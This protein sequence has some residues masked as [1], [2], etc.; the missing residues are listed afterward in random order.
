MLEYAQEE[1]SAASGPSDLTDVLGFPPVLEA[2]CWWVVSHPQ[3]GILPHTARRQ[4][5][6]AILDFCEDA[7]MQW[8]ALQR[9]GYHLVRATASFLPPLL[10]AEEQLQLKKEVG[11]IRETWEEAVRECITDPA[12]VERLL[13]LDDDATPEEVHAAVRGA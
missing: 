1:N 3:A 5:E 8:S 11:L 7:K 9:A 2:R 10:P 6:V 4:K 13:A 12:E